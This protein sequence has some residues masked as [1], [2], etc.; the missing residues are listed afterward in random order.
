VLVDDNSSDGTGALALELAVT[1]DVLSDG[2]NRFS[3]AVLSGKRRAVEESE[4]P[5]SWVEF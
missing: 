2:D 4:L 5:G 3:S 1:D